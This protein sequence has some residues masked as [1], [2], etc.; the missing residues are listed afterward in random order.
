VHASKAPG[1]AAG[2]A[3]HLK[4]GYDHDGNSN[5]ILFFE[6]NGCKGEVTNWVSIA[7]PG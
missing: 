7:L 2:M 1:K 3:E 4:R 6:C 5:N